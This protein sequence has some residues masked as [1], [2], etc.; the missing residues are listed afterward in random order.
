MLDK[1]ERGL[2][3]KRELGLFQITVAGIGIILGAGI[4]A[5]IG[6]AAGESGNGIWLSFL[7]AA[8]VAGFTGMSYAELS[9]MFKGDGGEYDYC[10]AAF[11]R[12]ISWLITLSIVV[13][14]IVTASAVSLGFAGYLV[15]IFPIGYLT[16]ALLLVVLMSFINY[17][18]IKESNR[19]NLIATTIEFIGLVIIILLGI[20]HVGSV[21]LLEF[22]NGVGGL[23]RSA[24]LVFFAYTGFE[25]IIKLREEAK[26]PNKTIPKAIVLSVFITAIVYVLVAIAA[27]SILPYSEL[28]ASSSPLADVAAVSFGKLAFIILGVIALF[29]TS[30]TVL[31]TMVTTSRMMY[32]VG[33][34]DRLWKIFSHVH[35]KRRTPY[36]AVIIIGIVTIVFT[37]IGNLEFVANL[38]T[39]LL[40][41]TFAMV[42]LGAII[43]RYKEGNRKREFRMPLN[44]GRFPI[45]AALGILTSL[46]MFVFSVMNIFGM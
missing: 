33:K 27:V 6:I 2:K 44:I 3:L 45:L 21:D 22:P 31:L 37:L 17:Y 4:Y 34:K 1:K 40:F 5:L 32:G 10:K 7:I 11:G 35:P 46:I 23:F 14:G 36:L 38:T 30:N 24:A 41:V 15:A 13:T 9:S 28:A 29:S 43:L 12:K 26:D 16:S 20:K 19:F 8:V 25:S 18:G 42:N 39:M